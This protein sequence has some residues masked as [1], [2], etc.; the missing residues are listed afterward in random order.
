MGG[1]ALTNIVTF[2][3]RAGRA[4]AAEAVPC[5]GEMSQIAMP[6]L[7]FPVR[8]GGTSPSEARERL[9]AISSKS[10]GP[11]RNAGE[12]RSCI[13][14]IGEWKSGTG[15]LAVKTPLD[16][17]HALEMKGLAV[18]AQ[19]VAAGALTREESR[20]VH[21]REDFPEECP[22]WKKRIRISLEKDTFSAV[23]EDIHS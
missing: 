8:E 10:L 1:N 4:A 13:E 17:L 21:F 5:G 9:R 12:L 18:T 3:L 15:P 19:A 11:C 6:T 20:G 7:Y 23:R 14:E 2:G 16:L 22:G